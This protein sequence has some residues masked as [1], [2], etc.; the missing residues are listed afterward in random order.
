M[1]LLYLCT[2]NSCRSQMAEGWTRSLK[3]DLITVYSAGIETHGL[4]PNAVKVM[5]EAGVDISG[6][7]SQHIDDFRETPIDVV[8]TVCDHAHETCPWFPADCKVVHHSFE[9]PPRLAR[10]LA[11][12]GASEEEQ[13]EPYRK[14][15]D[16]IKAYVQTLPESLNLQNTP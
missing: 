2:G 3:S 7:T 11:A 1:N 6:Q 4:N 9:D 16:S 5:A 10:E 13:L 14:V 12:N 15:R 8:V